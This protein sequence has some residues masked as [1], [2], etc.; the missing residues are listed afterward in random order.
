MFIRGETLLAHS[1][2]P[3]KNELVVA[4]ENFSVNKVTYRL[5]QWVFVF[6]FSNFN[7]TIDVILELARGRK[8]SG[9]Q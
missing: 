2:R 9:E 6:S 8:F 4:E 5:K 3:R 1:A 7:L